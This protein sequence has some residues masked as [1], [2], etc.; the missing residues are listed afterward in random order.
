VD[1]SALEGM[2][3]EQAINSGMSQ[4][5]QRHDAWKVQLV[6]EGKVAA[7]IDTNLLNMNTDQNELHEILNEAWRRGHT[8]TQAER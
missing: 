6:Y 5:N 3:P 8:G 4:I 1:G 2:T 7:N